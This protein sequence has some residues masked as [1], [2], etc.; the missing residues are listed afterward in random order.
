MVRLCNRAHPKIV[1]AI[2]L[3][4]ILCRNAGP[5]PHV[6]RE[7]NLLSIHLRQM[8]DSKT[9]S[10]QDIVDMDNIQRLNMINAISGFKSASLIG[11]VDGSGKENLAIFNSVIHIGSN[12]PLLGLLVR[13]LTVPRHTYQNIK[14]T[15]WFTV[16]HIRKEFYKR[17]HHTSGKFREDISEFEACGFKADYSKLCRAPYVKES[18]VRIG[19]SFEEE[20]EI[21]AN[22]TV[23]MIGAVRELTVPAESIEEDGFIDLEK[24]GSLTISGLDSYHETVRL[25]REEFVRLP[26]NLTRNN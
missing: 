23:L 15:G 25:S 10:Q 26:E 2:T 3:F 4:K 13:P 12:P 7:L 22:G 24:A 5:G 16:N 1:Y 21:K 9:Y 18:I 19:L 6:C 8:S 20:N 14:E 11:T 17:S